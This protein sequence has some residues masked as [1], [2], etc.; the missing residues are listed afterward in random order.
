[1]FISRWTVYYRRLKD[2]NYDDTERPCERRTLAILALLHSE[3]QSAYSA[4]ISTALRAELRAL[5][6][7][8]SIVAK[9][10]C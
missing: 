5:E 2:S 7:T 10:L 4:I 6:R 9:V 8:T 1:M 3:R